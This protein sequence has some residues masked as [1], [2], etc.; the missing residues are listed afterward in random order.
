MFLAVTV[1]CCLF[2]HNLRAR[3]CTYLTPEFSPSLQYQPPQKRA[4]YYS[5]ICCEKEEH[6]YKKISKIWYRCLPVCTRTRV[7]VRREC[8]FG[9]TCA[10]QLFWR[11]GRRSQERL[12][13]NMPNRSG[14]GY[15]ARRHGH[16]RSVMT[17]I[18]LIIT[19]G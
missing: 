2:P 9:R 1:A 15:N 10:R 11:L 14:R 8:V 19:C 3:A 16:D 12:F 5:C 6:V 18:I 17:T 13:T 4:T 7:W